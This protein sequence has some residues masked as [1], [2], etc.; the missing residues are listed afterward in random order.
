MKLIICSCHYASKYKRFEQPH[1]IRIL[2]ALV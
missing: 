1:M 2:E